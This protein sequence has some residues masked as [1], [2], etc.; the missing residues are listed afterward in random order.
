MPP[1]VEAQNPNHWTTRKVCIL[2]IFG[3]H[4]RC[5][6]VSLRK[7]SMEV[8]LREPGSGDLKI[9]T[10][11]IGPCSEVIKE[12]QLAKKWC[13][14]KQIVGLK[15]SHISQEAG[16]V[17]WYAHLLKNFLQFGVLHTVKGFGVVNKAE[18]DVF[19]ELS[20]FF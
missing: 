11:T 12:Q 7:T 20:H 2:F 5:Q 6:P 16:Q 19:L 3:L 18:A 14:L 10:C 8:G 9:F 17:V 4:R 1:V 15:M 13:P